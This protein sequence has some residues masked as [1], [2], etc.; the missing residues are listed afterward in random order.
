M[1]FK[2]AFKCIRL[3]FLLFVLLGTVIGW[4]Y[5]MH[6]TWDDEI[7]SDIPNRYILLKSPDHEQH[8]LLDQDEIAALPEEYKR[9]LA[10]VKDNK[11]PML[12][13]VYYLKSHD[14]QALKNTIRIYNPNRE[15]LLTERLE[16]DV[17]FIDLENEDTSIKVTIAA[18]QYIHYS[19]KP[20]TQYGN[21][22]ITYHLDNGD[23]LKAYLNVIVYENLLQYLIC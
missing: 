8:R 10:I 19:C 6:T 21:A 13:E 14:N 22:S 5:H 7:K 12:H 17:T 2:A 11:V 1:R 23:K 15:G 20:Y 18:E 16:K 4:D 3:I 9:P